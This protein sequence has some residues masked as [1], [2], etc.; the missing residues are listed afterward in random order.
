MVD[1]VIQIIY[2]KSISY[3]YKS[4]YKSEKKKKKN[5]TKVIKKVICNFAVSYAKQAA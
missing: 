4:V 3:G 5:Q 2:L 1:L